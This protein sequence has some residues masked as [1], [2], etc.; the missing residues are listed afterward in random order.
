MSIKTIENFI[1]PDF[2]EWLEWFWHQLP[3]KCDTGQKTRT[4]LHHQLPWNRR[5]HDKLYSMMAPYEERDFSISTAYLSDDYAPGGIHSDG[6]LA[7]YPEKNLSHTYLVPL[8]YEGKQHTIVF[9]QTSQ[10]AVTL[11][12]ALGMG[13][14]G[15]VNYRQVDPQTVLRDKGI[16]IS[17]E[18]YNEYLTH[19]SY[20][21][22]QGLTISSILT[23]NLD[24][25]VC[26]PREHFHCAANYIAGQQR[27]AL[28]MMTC[29]I[30]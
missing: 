21:C 17:P 22:L 11:N 10:E 7:S 19:L 23:W 9:D 20:E 12:S 18:I 6:F 4:F 26:W 29:Y 25:A 27:F 2:R 30:D 16:H 5:L 15:I 3:D 1:E 24:A 14:A 13:N 28:I 8:A